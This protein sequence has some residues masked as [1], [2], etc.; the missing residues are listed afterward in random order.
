MT[1]HRSSSYTMIN[2][3]IYG[4]RC[5]PRTLLTNLPEDPA[6]RRDVFL[7]LADVLLDDDRPR[8]ALESLG[9]AEAVSHDERSR[10]LREAIEARIKK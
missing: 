6:E 2:I 4:A 1:I 9:V 5:K 10:R 8:S 3:I 7:R